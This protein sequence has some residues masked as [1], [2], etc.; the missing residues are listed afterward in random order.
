MY[1]SLEKFLK[2]YIVER[3]FDIANYLLDNNCTVRE[4][5]REF[6]VSKSTAHKDISE[7]LYCLDRELFLKVSKIMNDNWNERYLRGGE[8]TKRKF[9][10]TDGN[11]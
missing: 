8:A 11:V 6:C 7:R 5:A 1:K 2:D 9:K 10:K 3:V 4:A